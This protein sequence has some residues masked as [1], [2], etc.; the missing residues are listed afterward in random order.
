MPER[1]RVGRQRARPRSEDDAAAGHVIE[2]HDP[3]RDVERMVERQ[4]HDA[5]AELD[6]VRALAGGGEEHLG[7][8]DHLPARRVVLAAPELVVAELVEVLGQIQVAAELERRMLADR[9]VG[10]R[11]APKPSLVMKPPEVSA[12]RIVST[13][14]ILRC[15]RG[16]TPS[17]ARPTVRRRRPR[18]QIRSSGLVTPKP[19]R[20]STWV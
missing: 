12:D 7:R 13:R 1:E 11:N 10:A 9:V 2:L 19:P 5:G 20:L 15:W 17:P 3:L 6:A 8:R 16:G 14:S 18:D 4:R